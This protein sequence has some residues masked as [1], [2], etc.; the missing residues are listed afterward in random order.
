MSSSLSEDKVYDLE[1]KVFQRNVIKKYLYT[2]DRNSNT[3]GIAQEEYTKDYQVQMHR[4]CFSQL[5]KK[6]SR[7]IWILE[8]KGVVLP[9]EVTEQ[10][11]ES[12][13]A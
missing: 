9:L 2:I 7:Y 8:Q 10:N 13:A 1:L 4:T 11:T 3:S 5:R 12:E 6:N